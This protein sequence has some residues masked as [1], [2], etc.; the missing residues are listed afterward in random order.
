MAIC[1]QGIKGMMISIVCRQVS[2]QLE[3]PEDATKV[4]NFHSVLSRR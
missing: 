4:M 2:L 1:E 3:D